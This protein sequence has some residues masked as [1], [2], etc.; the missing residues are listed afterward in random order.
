M[1]A[2]EN[3]RVQISL[4]VPPDHLKLG[5]PPREFDRALLAVCM[6][7]VRAGAIIVYGGDLRPEGFAFKIFRHLARGYA[8]LGNVPFVHII[9]HPSV[10]SMTYDVLADALR[11]RRGTCNTYVCANDKL[12]PVRLGDEEVVMGEGDTAVELQDD[13]DLTSW[14]ASLGDLDIVLATSSARRVLAEFVDACVPIG[15]KMGL[16]DTEG[17]QYHGSMP[18]IIE[19]ALLALDKGK[20]MIP[21]AAYGGATRDLAISLQLLDKASEV[22]R[23]RQMDSYGNALTMAAGFRNHIPVS[24]VARLNAVARDDRAEIIARDTVDII[25]SWLSDGKPQTA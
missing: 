5:I 8:D 19:E 1:N 25:Q 18:G 7:L 6:A 14:V 4:S 23:G 20:A 15:G 22:P 21:L 16:L 2:L 3:V 10:A 17:D 12:F 24:V 9:S 11:E 13:R